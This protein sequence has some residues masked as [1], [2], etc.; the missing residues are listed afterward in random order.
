MAQG[1]TAVGI[2]SVAIDPRNSKYIY[3]GSSEGYV[4]R[5]TD[6]G[7]TWQDSPLF[8][9][10][11]TDIAVDPL[12]SQKIYLASSYI[13]TSTDQ[14]VTFKQVDAV[15]SATVIA[16]TP[17]ASGPIYVGTDFG[18]GIYKSSDGGVSWVQ[19]NEG[20]PLSGGSI[21]TILSLAV[22]PGAPSRVWAGLSLGT[23]HSQ[24]GIVRSDNG[25]DHW[26][27]RGLSRLMIEA[28][29][30]HPANGNTILVGANYYSSDVTTQAGHFSSGSA[31]AHPLAV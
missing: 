10:P 4:I 1:I 31:P 19:K 7:L 21:S 17:H 12:N 8:S 28:I 3:A 30:I 20:L 11:V 26:Y 23:D 14:G 13:Y 25:G 16:V 15:R 9:W 27:G 6:G 22:D 5:T 18:G 29:A 24:P 2:N